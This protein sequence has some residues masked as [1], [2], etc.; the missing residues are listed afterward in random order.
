MYKWLNSYEKVYV[1]KK[2]NSERHNIAIYSKT[3]EFKEWF[4]GFLFHLQCFMMNIL[5]AIGTH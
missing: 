1:V 4:R 3:F 2:E 5:L